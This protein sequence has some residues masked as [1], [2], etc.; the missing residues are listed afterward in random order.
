MLVRENRSA[1]A[2]D[3]PGGSCHTLGTVRTDVGLF[4]AELLGIAGFVAGFAAAA[5]G[6]MHRG[7]DNVAGFIQVDNGHHFLGGGLTAWQLVLHMHKSM[8]VLTR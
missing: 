2:L 8:G 4:C 3:L 7:N 5:A 1:Y 6:Q